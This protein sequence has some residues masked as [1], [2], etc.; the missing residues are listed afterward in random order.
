MQSQP[1]ATGNLQ[2]WVSHFRTEQAEHLEPSP[3]RAFGEDKLH[4]LLREARP[5]LNNAITVKR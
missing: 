2:V 4:E 5:V 1:K 3:V